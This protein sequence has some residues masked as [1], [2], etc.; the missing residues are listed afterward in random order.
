MKKNKKFAG[1]LIILILLA[2]GLF[3][4]G[5]A[6]LT[7]PP[8]SVGVI[9]SKTFGVDSRPVREGDFRWLWFKI[10]PTNVRIE[11]YKPTRLTR[12]F[13][14]EGALPS[15]KTYAV[16]AGINETF[17]WRV[18]GSF[19]F[20]L[21]I[22]RIPQL[23]AEGIFSDQEG[24]D[25]WTK[26]LADDIEAFIFQ[27]VK[28]YGSDDAKMRALLEEGDLSSITAD[29]SGAF[30]GIEH[31]SCALRSV[32]F[33]DFALYAQVKQI[34]TDYLERQRRSLANTSDREAESRLRSRLRMAE[35]TEYGE[36]I[37][38]YPDLIQYL[39][40]EKGISPFPSGQMR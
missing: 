11:V 31:F 6:Q 20:S 19:S 38:K 10:I 35:L 40:I 28:A 33:P 9:R 1:V 14:T 21:K 8:G 25:T 36:L 5:W 22:D 34:Y 30:P 29:V 24:L 16:I 13:T 4:A 15:G 2:G 32:T 37:S 12:P 18:Q 7:V 3:F 23:A 26:K 27:R 17:A 39:G